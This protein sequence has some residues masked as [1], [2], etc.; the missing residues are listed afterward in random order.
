VN[1]KNT[2]SQQLALEKQARQKAET[3][4]SM[5]HAIT[6]VLA[7]STVLEKIAPKI[8]KV[9]C[10]TL[11]FPV[12]AVWTIDD[13]HPALRC[14]AIWCNEETAAIKEFAELSK[15][16]FFTQNKGLPGRVWKDKAICYLEEVVTDPNFPRAAWALKANLHSAIGL[17][18]FFEEEFIGVI[19]FFMPYIQ[20][21][22]EQLKNSLTDITNQLGVFIGREQA[23]KK[24][25]VELKSIKTIGAL[26]S[27]LKK[28]KEEAESANKLKSAFVAN[29]SHELRTPLNAILGYSEMLQ[30]EAE[31]LGQTESVANLNK[32]IDAGKHLLSLI[33]NV[34]D[35]SRLDAGKI[36][37]LLEGVNIQ[38]LA[39]ELNSLAIPLTVKNNNT[40]K[41]I[42]APELDTMHTDNVRVRQAVLNLI[43]NAG[44]FTENGV[45]TLEITPLFQDKK[46]WIQFSVTDTGVGIGSEKL[47][48]LFQ[49]FFQID[50]SATRRYGGTGLGL[51]LTKQ[52]CEILGGWVTVKSTENK[53]ST[54]S[55][56]I[57]Q[58]STTGIEKTDFI[59]H[60]SENNMASV[61]SD[62]TVLIID[63][64][65]KLHKEMEYHLEQAGFTVYH[66]FN[67]EEGL[68]LTKIVKPAIII[69]DVIM[70]VMDG[71]TV[72][73]SL[74]SDSAVS[75]I[76]VILMSII[77]EQD[78]GFALGAIDY[79]HKPI[80]TET[81][82]TKIKKLEITNGLSNKIMTREEQHKPQQHM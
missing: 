26:V 43:S 58:K 63:D 29:M 62:K 66:A 77:S 41:L 21:L 24:V 33:N 6:R 74:K 2:L 81:L 30:E 57:P 60:L 51:Y 45:I 64:D 3:Y 5:G 25:F 8:L 19:E 31:D 15:K 17:P 36:E 7:A 80:N 28:A 75:N 12:G 67:G 73:S 13:T 53:G 32:I 56:I 22:D 27:E 20:T 76:P 42:I 1:K 68:N 44:K 18:L 9:I 65:H 82:V 61:S 48:E 46:E 23:Q 49:V 69:L 38:D 16:S 39:K 40:F 50:A 72:L 34:L 55:M 70:P 4:L 14:T 10:N 71:W 37:L 78:L 47:D 52:F 59:N 35:L 79:I 11:A 54:F